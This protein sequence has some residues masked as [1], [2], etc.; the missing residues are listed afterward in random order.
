MV[1]LPEQSRLVYLLLRLLCVT[2]VV[3]TFMPTDLDVELAKLTLTP[4]YAEAR[5][6]LFRLPARDNSTEPSITS[7]Y[8]TPT[9]LEGTIFLTPL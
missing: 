2:R 6:R 9:I 4:E 5:P 7:R 8:I 1:C 3:N